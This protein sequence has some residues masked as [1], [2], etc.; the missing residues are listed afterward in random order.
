VS[1]QLLL[2]K[3][4]DDERAK[5]KEQF[6]KSLE[7]YKA[8]RKISNEEFAKQLGP[9][10][11]IQGVTREQWEKQQIDQAVLPLVLEREL[12]VN[13]TDE[14]VKKFYDSKPAQLEQP[15]MVRASHIL[16]STKDP[17]DT[18][19]NMGARRDLPEEQKKARHKQMEDILKRAKS[20]EDF[21][22]LAS[23]YSDDPGSKD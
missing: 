18:N 23:Q 19:P 4:T 9:Q 2:S 11:R 13:V 15:E 5:A 17:A 16:L 21:S 6:E 14:E 7:T 3:A 20:G 22:K 10:L 12:K 1:M 8:D